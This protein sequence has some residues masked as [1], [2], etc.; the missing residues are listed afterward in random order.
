[1]PH[2]GA[3]RRSKLLTKGDLEEIAKLVLKI[4]QETAH[5]CIFEQEDI[6][7]VRDVANIFRKVKNKVFD[8]VYYVIMAIILG[9]VILIT[10]HGTWKKWW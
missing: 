4:Q 6:E 8:T 2:E 7:A 5:H 3:E 1:M 9:T 10:T